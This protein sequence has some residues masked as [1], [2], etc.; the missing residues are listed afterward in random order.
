MAA[1]PYLLLTLQS[2]P[3]DPVDNAAAGAAAQVPGRRLTPAGAPVPE[4]R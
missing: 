1:L 4:A 2:E 3:P